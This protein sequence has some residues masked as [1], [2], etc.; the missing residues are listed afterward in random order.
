MVTKG[1]PT[2]CSQSHKAILQIQ[3]KIKSTHTTSENDA[4]PSPISTPVTHD[5]GAQRIIDTITVLHQS[6]D[7]VVSPNPHRHGCLTCSREII[8]SKLF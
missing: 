7:R 1:K 8:R 6:L 5:E 2:A 4:F 3:D